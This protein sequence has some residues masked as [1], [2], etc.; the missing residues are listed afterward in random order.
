VIELTASEGDDASQNGLLI[1]LLEAWT[2]G[3]N[4]LYVVRAMGA[5]D[6][7]LAA[8]LGSLL[9]PGDAMVMLL[10]TAISGGVLAVVYAL[11]RRRIR[12]TL[13]NVGAALQFH[14][15]SGLRIHP[16]LNLDN[17]VALRIGHCRGHPLRLP[18]NLV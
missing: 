10:A 4:L 8:A 5:G 11:Y 14:A 7:K 9:G 2:G 13:P 15:G 12:A 18:D 16:D 17:P 3:R 1:A 6:V